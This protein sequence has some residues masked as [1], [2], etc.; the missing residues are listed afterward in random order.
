[1]TVAA[2]SGACWV[3]ATNSTT[4]ATL[5]A[6]TLAAGERQSFNAASPATVIVGA[7]TV[8]VAS[9]DGV[10]VVMP[11]GFQTPFTMSFVMSAAPA[12]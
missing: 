10:A 9:V 7:P 1:M 4:G 5:Y 8:F 3:D 11:S 6:G 2:T 12:S